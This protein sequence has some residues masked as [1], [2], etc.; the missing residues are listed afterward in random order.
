MVLCYHVLE[1][2]KDDLAAMSEIKRIC[3]TSGRIYIQVPFKEGLLK[4]VEYDAPDPYCH[5]HV[6][7]YG[8]DF[9]DRVTASGLKFERRD[10][11]VWLDNDKRQALA[12]HKA[13]GVTYICSHGGPG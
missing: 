2:V 1:H 8:A 5:D 7:E 9:E 13:A 3:S 4:T 12:A 11:G 10:F 6:R